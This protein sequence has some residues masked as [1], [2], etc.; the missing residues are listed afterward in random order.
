METS[1][2]KQTAT[3]DFRAETQNHSLD[4]KFKNLPENLN[5]LL[6]SV[7]IAFTD[8]L[9]KIKM[10]FLHICFPPF[11]V[12]YNVKASQHHLFSSQWLFYSVCWRIDFN[13]CW[14]LELLSQFPN[15]FYYIE[16][17]FLTSRKLWTWLVSLG[18]TML[19]RDETPGSNVLEPG[20]KYMLFLQGKFSF[21]RDEW[22]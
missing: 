3:L 7:L 6:G 2:L 18:E 19:V 22:K 10:Q 17:S 20:N 16:D 1:L 5:F 21:L 12:S 13:G 9:Y 14:W 15:Q 4:K 11:F 8:L